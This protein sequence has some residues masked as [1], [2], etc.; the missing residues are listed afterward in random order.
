MKSFFHKHESKRPLIHALE[1]KA[2]LS[3]AERATE[4]E[5]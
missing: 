2:L 1:S 5:L 4:E 3:E